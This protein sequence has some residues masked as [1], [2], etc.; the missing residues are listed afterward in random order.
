MK[1]SNCGKKLERDAAFCDW[2]GTPS[3]AP[4]RRC[5]KCGRQNGADARFCSGCGSAL[6]ATAPAEDYPQEEFSAPFSFTPPLPDTIEPAFAARAAEE[7]MWD[8][9][10]LLAQSRQPSAETSGEKEQ[11]WSVDVLLS[12]MEQ[13]PVD[14]STAEEQN[15]NVD[16]LLPERE[17][18]PARFP[19]VEEQDW[20][21][22]ENESIEIQRAVGEPE[23]VQD[24]A[25]EVGPDWGHTISVDS[26]VFSPERGA[27]ACVKCGAALEDGVHFCMVCGHPCGDFPVFDEEQPGFI[28]RIP[29]VVVDFG[30]ESEW[31][32]PLDGQEDDSF[33]QSV[34]AGPPAC[35][36][37]GALLDDDVSLCDNC[38]SAVN[39]EADWRN[40]SA[41]VQ[42]KISLLAVL[43]MAVLAL[44]LLAVAAVLAVW[45]NCFGLGDFAREKE[46][47]TFLTRQQQQNDANLNGGDD[48]QEGESGEDEP[49]QAGTG[50]AGK[51]VSPAYEAA[52]DFD[53]DGGGKD[54]RAVGF[55]AVT[56][57]ASG[58][59]SK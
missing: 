49:A 46:V 38:G 50:A 47:L 2:C 24:D 57:T 44:V 33:A 14:F 31:D 25:T 17:Q 16:E 42:K 27:P 4:G 30:A 19:T 35:G 51:Q 56:E 7:R 20:N 9:D 26:L 48:T 29:A 53:V 54:R 40:V 28:E 3:S 5:G 58:S 6:T 23:P 11:A 37:C 34:P 8:V 18:S 13:P 39:Q 55:L 59:L 10:E 21:W 43:L 15:E 32:E 1:C 22:D 41:P 45:L 52:Y 36:N 12:E